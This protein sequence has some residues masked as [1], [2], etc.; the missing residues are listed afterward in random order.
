MSDRQAYQP[1]H[2]QSAGGGQPYAATGGIAR[3]LG[4]LRA[5]VPQAI[6]L[7]ACVIVAEAA[8]PPAAKPST[9]LGSFHGS[10]DTAEINAKQGAVVQFEED[11]TSARTAPPANW[12]MEAQVAAQQQQAVA[13]ALQAQAGMANLADLACVTGGILGALNLGGEWN[14]AGEKMTGACGVG[15]Q[16]RK[17]MA[18]TLATTARDNSALV[19]RSAPQ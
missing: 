14:Q 3:S 4:Y 11:M 15:D 8:L 19:K 16:F 7:A 6:V 1:M 5:L 12:Q 13:E 9:L 2:N 18:D 17:S 10:L